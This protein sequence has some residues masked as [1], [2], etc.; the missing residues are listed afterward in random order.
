METRKRYKWRTQKAW[1]LSLYKE[2]KEASAF[3]L[4][5]IGQLLQAQ[6]N[7]VQQ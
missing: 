7:V 5:L 6:A 4:L 2:I 3:F 1:P